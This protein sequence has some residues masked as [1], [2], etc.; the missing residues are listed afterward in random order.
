MATRRKIFDQL[1]ARARRGTGAATA[2]W[3]CSKSYQE[4]AGR[5]LN[6]SST[7]F[8]NGQPGSA[9]ATSTVTCGDP[10]RRAVACRCGARGIRSL[11]NGFGGTVQ[12]PRSQGVRQ[13][14]SYGARASTIWPTGREEDAYRDNSEYFAGWSIQ[15][16]YERHY[17]Y[18]C[19]R[20]K[21]C[22][23]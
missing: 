22:S 13:I 23:A 14:G 10:R 11:S 20:M 1:K 5:P 4:L 15:A 17:R 2:T 6:G 19:A 12:S 7:R 21:P 16:G 3:R 9:R 18:R 8:S